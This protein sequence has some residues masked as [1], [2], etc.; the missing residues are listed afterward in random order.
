MTFDRR[1]VAVVE[2]VIF[3]FDGQPFVMRIE[4]PSLGHRPALEHTV[5]LGPEIIV[6]P[7][8]VVPLDHEP[9]RFDG[10]THASPLGSL[11]FLKSRLARYFER[12][13]AMKLSWRN[14]VPVSCWLT[15]WDPQRADISETALDG[16]NLA[17]CDRVR[18]LV[19]A[20]VDVGAAGS[21]LFRAAA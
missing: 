7:R 19:L 3:D 10:L 17:E 1:E 14:T 13:S 8:G 16:G 5:K 18:P 9:T 15:M 6:Q 2:Q 12:V 21:A 4:R 11:V 20:P